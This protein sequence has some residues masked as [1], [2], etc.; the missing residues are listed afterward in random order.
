MHVY[1]ILYYIFFYV[2]GI[3][4]LY[5]IELISINVPLGMPTNNIMLG[6]VP[7]IFC[8]R[9]FANYSIL[10]IATPTLTVLVCQSFPY[11]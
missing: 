6:F 10:S 7:M 11:I 8:N 3:F 4:L 9:F 5:K 1:N 2:V